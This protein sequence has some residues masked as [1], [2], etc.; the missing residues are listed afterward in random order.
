MKQSENVIKFSR[1][2]IF[3]TSLQVHLLI[4]NIAYDSIDITRINII[5][6]GTPITQIM[7]HND[8]AMGNRQRI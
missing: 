7:R 5:S 2:A 6:W 3:H 8:C 4:L 1:L